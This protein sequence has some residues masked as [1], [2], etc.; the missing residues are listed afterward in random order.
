MSTEPSINP[1]RHC[2]KWL[3]WAA[4]ATWLGLPLLA[5]GQSTPPAGA[6]A[7]PLSGGRGPG[8]HSPLSAFAPLPQRDDV[9]AWSTLARVS[10][11]VERSRMVPVYSPDILALNQRTVRLQGFMA[12]LDP[13]ER[14]STFL[15]SSVPL[16]CPFCSPGGAESIVQVIAR[17]PIR[18]TME[19]LVVEG[20]F[21]VLQQDALGFF[22][23]LTAAVAVR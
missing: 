18:Y 3:A 21:H 17:S 19:G 9:V 15:L 11:R 22:Y 5:L 8:Y 10:Q 20:R 16:T 23:R 14:Q 6:E 1:R 7:N 4:G 12:P 2:L 13:G